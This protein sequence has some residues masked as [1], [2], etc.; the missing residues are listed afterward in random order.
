M[1][2]EQFVKGVDFIWDG[3]VNSFKLAQQL[4]D[5]FEQKAFTAFTYQKDLLDAT[6]S[7]V[8]SIEE[9]SKKLTK[10][11]QEKAQQ[12]I[13]EANNYGQFDQ[14]TKWLEGVQEIAEQ[15]QH[16]AWKPTHV[17][18]DLFVQSH[19]QLESSLKDALV[20][21]KNERQETFRKIEE[22]ATQL[23]GAQKNLFVTQ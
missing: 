13:Q 15:A 19:T 7:A 1:A 8:K 23:K 2:N 20:L 6:V 10:E 14:V 11:W 17:L 18:A 4:Q 16:L 3:W 12:N 21:Q 5:E 9:E 22:L